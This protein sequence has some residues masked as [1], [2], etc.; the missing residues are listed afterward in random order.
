MNGVVPSQPARSTDHSATVHPDVIIADANRVNAESVS[1]CLSAYGT[2]RAAR[3][4]TSTAQLTSA[5]REQR[6]DLVVICENIVV[7]GFREIAA[8]LAVRLGETRLAVFADRLTD[9]QLDL[10][11]HN[12]ITGLLSRQEEM[13]TINEQLVRIVAGTP[14]VS[15]LLA[16]RVRLTATG[17]FECLASRQLQK[18]T[19]RQWDVLLR[20]AE[21]RRV[22]EVAA[23][24]SITE[25]AVES[26][27]YRIMRTIGATDRVELCRWAIREGFID[28]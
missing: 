19:D 4:V 6:P 12:R 2:F 8:E 7:Q 22:S 21:G 13:R 18:L 20:I 3:S 14:V 24:L 26:H 23:D 1:Y 17:E 10:V 15:P 5:I 11:T 25:K 9:R 16:D 28:A 27:K